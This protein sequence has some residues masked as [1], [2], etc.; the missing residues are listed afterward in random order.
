MFGAGTTLENQMQLS[1]STLTV[2]NIQRNMAAEKFIK[3]NDLEI[4]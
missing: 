2:S 1:A 4:F 3:T